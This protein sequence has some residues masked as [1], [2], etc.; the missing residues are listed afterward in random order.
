[1]N[2]K[3]RKKRNRTSGNIFIIKVTVYEDSR[4]NDKRSKLYTCFIDLRKRLSSMVSR[5]QAGFAEAVE[6][7]TFLQHF[8]RHITMTRL[9]PQ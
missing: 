3:E 5:T 9:P 7:Q 2:K 4:K 6:S 8:S 1:M